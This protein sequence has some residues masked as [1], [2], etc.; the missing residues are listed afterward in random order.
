LWF[1]QD[2]LPKRIAGRINQRTPHLVVDIEREPAM[3]CQPGTAPLLPADGCFDQRF[4]RRLVNLLN[5]GPGA[6]VRHSG[7]LGRFPPFGFLQPR[8]HH[9]REESGH[10]PDDEHPAPRSAGADGA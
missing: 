10:R 2:R 1:G 9:Q 6:A 8:A 7:R 4:S 3:R 5:H